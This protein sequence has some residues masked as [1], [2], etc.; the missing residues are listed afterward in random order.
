MTDFTRALLRQLTRCEVCVCRWPL[1]RTMTP[2]VSQVPDLSRSRLRD[3][4]RVR[5][6]V[7]AIQIE[8][9]R[10]LAV[11]QFIEWRLDY[12]E[13]ELNVPSLSAFVYLKMRG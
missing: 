11:S 4:V 12:N 3:S 8:P 1:M 9:R 10:D 13:Y 7:S 6:S 2:Q 5:L